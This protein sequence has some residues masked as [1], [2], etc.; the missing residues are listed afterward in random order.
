VNRSLSVVIVVIGAIVGATLIVLFNANEA[1]LRA[2]VEEDPRTRGRLVLYLLSI[3]VAGP[4]LACS[5]Y[6]WFVDRRRL[7][8]IVAAVLAVAALA[9]VFLLFRLANLLEGAV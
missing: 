3:A 8:R 7:L 9:I 2:W 4:V 1:E 5:A 6:L